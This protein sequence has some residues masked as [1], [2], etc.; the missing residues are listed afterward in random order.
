MLGVCGYYTIRK[1]KDGVQT[2]EHRFKNMITDAGLHVIAT[3]NLRLG[4][5]AI[6]SDTRPVTNE[7]NEVGTV[8]GYGTFTSAGLDGKTEK[9]NGQEYY[10]SRRVAQFAKNSAVGNLSKVGVLDESGVYFSI[11][12]ITDNE[13]RP[14]TI[15]VL[16]DETLEIEYELQFRIGVG[17]LDFTGVRL[18]ANLVRNGT[19]G[20]NKLYGASKVNVF[21]GWRTHNFKDP[22][23]GDDHVF[24]NALV[25]E[26]GQDKAKWNT[27]L[28]SLGLAVARRQGTIRHYIGNA[29]IKQ[30][31]TDPTLMEV[32]LRLE[33]NDYADNGYIAGAI[34]TTF[35]TFWFQFD[36]KVIKN[37]SRTS[38]NVL[39]TVV[40]IVRV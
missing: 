29:S 23:Y 34:C 31:A 11:A 7:S 1:Y 30:S 5:M 8:V 15:T 32:I 28:P 24:G 38:V 6:S 2:Y 40:R 18:N 20:F 16:R 21:Q 36:N 37:A 12:L 13:G 39:T 19:F 9:E 17:Q 22:A 27:A 4:R 26:V 25:W 35:G 10:W 3:G 33:A 14:T